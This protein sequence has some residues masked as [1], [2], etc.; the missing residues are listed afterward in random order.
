MTLF[1]YTI[2]I[3]M[4]SLQYFFFRELSLLLHINVAL[5]NVAFFLYI[6]LYLKE[7]IYSF[8]TCLIWE[9]LQ[10]Q[11]KCFFEYCIIIFIIIFNLKKID[12]L[13]KYLLLGFL[14]LLFSFL[15][16]KLFRLIFYKYLKSNLVIIGTNN[17]AFQLINI[18]N[19]NR[20]TMYNFLGFVTMNDAFKTNKL[21]KI[22]ADKNSFQ[23]F[24]ANNKVDEVIIALPNLSD[25]DLNI[26]IEKIESFVKKI[27]IVPEIHKLYGVGSTIQNY[28]GFLLISTKKNIHSFK[29]KI[30]KRCLDILGGLVGVCLLIPLY[31]KY[32]L[33]IK[34]DGG[35]AFFSH[36]RIGKNLKPFKM[37]KFRSMYIDAEDRLQQL[38][39]SDIELKNEY[40]SNFK[41]KNDPRVTEVGRFL[42]KTSLDE[43]P[44][45]INVLKGN[46]SLVGPRPVVLK[47]V[48]MYYGTDIGQKIFQMKPGITGMWQ[49]SGRSDIENYEDRIQLDLYYMRNWSIWLDIVILIKTLKSVLKKE[50]A[51]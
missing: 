30:C 47:E 40:Y 18:I 35:N 29:R 5:R 44:Q 34:K 17:V 27:K 13:W 10:K 36:N 16:A 49:V 50:G 2:A 3:F 38:L 11:L 8:N 43:F 23:Q 51:Y 12:Q 22:I 39:D 9:E 25:T 26:I 28:D 21:N 20:F 33:E 15:L 7:K 1:Y 6:F 19:Q 4:I 45:F 14:T 48:E 24:F 32:G 37:Y 46:M 31:I 42:R 41:L